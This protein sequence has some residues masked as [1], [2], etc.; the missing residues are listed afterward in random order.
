MEHQEAR[1]GAPVTK[2]AL[3]EL[4]ARLRR[5]VVGGFVPETVFQQ[6]VRRLGL[7]TDER[8]RLR[9]ELVRL[10]VPVQRGVVHAHVDIPDVQKVARNRVETVFPP[11]DRVLVLLER[12]ADDEGYVTPRVV[13]GVVRLCGLN[14]RE[15][16]T[17][18]RAARTRPERPPA[19]STPEGPTEA[20]PGGA[21]GEPTTVGDVRVVDA[22]PAPEEPP[23]GGADD[24]EEPAGGPVEDFPYTQSET[25]AP[26]DA[27]LAEAVAAARAVMH[28]DR[29]RRRPGNH[30]LT[31][32][33]EVGLA[34]L[35][36][37]G[38]GEE[39]DQETL[40]ALPPDDIRV[41]A[42][43]C[44]VV[45]NQRLVHSIVPRYLDQGLDYDDVV[46]HG[47]L[48]LMRAARKFDPAKGFKFSTYATWW[49]RQS[50]GRAIADEGSLIR[51]PV[52]MHEQIRKVANAER[53][54]AAQGRPAGPADVAVLCDLPLSKVEEARRLS[55]RTDSLDRVVGD[56][57]TLG[58]FVAR[59]RAVPSFE[60]RVHDALLLEEAMA[61]LDTFSGRDH[62]ILVRR[63]GLD[64]EDPSTLD[65]LGGE[66][67]VTRER[68]R[69]LEAKLVP[70]LRS[71]L[72][73][74]RL[75]G[76]RAVAAREACESA[77]TARAAA[78]GSRAS[79]TA[80]APVTTAPEPKTV[81]VPAVILPDQDTRWA[82]VTP[83]DS[84]PAGDVTSTDAPDWDRARRLAAESPSGQA[85]LAN[86]ALAALG[87]RGVAEVLGRTAAEKVLRI[88]REREPA[89]QPVLRALDVLRR[90]CDGVAQAG[91]RPED[92]LDRSS[93]ALCGVTPR[94]YLARKPLVYGEPR[95]AVR[96]ALQEFLASPE[97]MVSEARAVKT[98][99]AVPV[100]PGP[101]E[102]APPLTPSAESEPVPG[103]LPS[104]AG[105]VDEAGQEP[106]DA[107][108]SGATTR[109]A[110]AADDMPVPPQYTAD[111]DRARE[112]TPPFGGEV[113]WLA[114]YAL[115]AVG[116]LQLGVLLG[117]S[118]ADAVVRAG[119]ERGMLNRHVVRALE[120]L[121][122]IFD[123]VKE[124]GLRP[125][126]FFEWSSGHLAGATP[127][128]YLAGK[129]LVDN[130]ARVAVRDALRDFVTAH[131]PGND[132]EP[133]AEAAGAPERSPVDVEHLLAE[134]RARHEA[135][136]ARLAEAHERRL[137]EE[138]QTADA[139]VMAA[140]AEAAQE[141]DDLEEILLY[142]V[143][144]ALARQ[145]QHLRR[146]A[147]ERVAQLKEEHRAATVAAARRTQER[148]VDLEIRLRQAESAGSTAAGERVSQLQ[149]RAEQ[150]EQRLQ[151]YRDESEARIAHLESRLRQTETRLIAR[152]RAMY[153]AGQRAVADVEQA[154]QRAE[155]A[156]QRAEALLTAAREAEARA[157]HGRQLATARLAQVERD[158]GA[159]IGELQAQL[160]AL[161][162]PAGGRASLRDRWRRS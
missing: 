87:G 57:A 122:E 121:E 117:P 119:Q 73:A 114:G 44:L 29:F 102:Q 137:A 109:S 45:H 11:L 4:M 53:S 136:V 6:E 50:I 27:D 107:E 85:W 12:Y 130:S 77:G 62:R 41:Q 15:A 36:R 35:V 120:V 40:S 22:G 124:L 47:T 150:A 162:E 145:E 134:V 157:V 10:R 83:D 156:E 139:R 113:A 1:R 115:L 7:G 74:A 123:A 106:A 129:P 72:R 8:E 148:V 66:F 91:L 84:V 16:A 104:D 154:Q 23:G 88:A 81:V 70:E 144:K 48:G 71:R 127:R 141:L 147:E 98:G 126:H 34:V 90:V 110:A 42:R 105:V 49:V 132:A 68:I 158:A 146:Q 159:R 69:Q 86:Y 38:T 125:E 97:A 100:R 17:L 14:A 101:A 93:E 142:R 59:T 28:E 20:V 111:W 153:E 140:R 76:V 18:S 64:G 32:Q 24:A 56:G 152:D 67:G 61:V 108:S 33:Q 94:A 138:R 96:E 13:E 118:A 60:E 160:A 95:L 39:P 143:D 99:E 80:R 54:L 21:G 149:A 161:Q 25:V 43:N 58:D 103:P 51:V 46:Q 78:S 2:A 79:R 30:L 52:H 75:L 5:A 89:D 135:E 131:S 151:R 133:A 112:L 128:A 116:H 55:R 65:Q 82:S 26:T 92:F 37:G 31:A 155:A 63:L 9:G 19:V 3:T